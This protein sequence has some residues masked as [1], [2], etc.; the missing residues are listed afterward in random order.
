MTRIVSS[1]YRNGA[2][3]GKRVGMLEVVERLP[4]GKFRCVCDC[5]KERI[6]NV[7]HFN[8]GYAK[9]CGCTRFQ[10]YQPDAHGQCIIEGCESERCNSH[11]YCW[12]HYMRWRRHG[13]PLFTTKGRPQKWLLEHV[14]YEGDDCLS[15]PFG[16]RNNGY[17]TLV[18][19]GN[20]TSAHRQMCTLVHGDPPSPRHEAAHSCGNG[21][22]GCVNP[23]HLR[24]ATP[25][26]NQADKLLH[27]THNRGE[28]SGSA[29]LKERQVH[30]IRKMLAS[31]HKRAEIAR[32]F[33]VT[34]G[35]I[36]GIAY[37]KTWAWLQ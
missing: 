4:G 9:S 7:G 2:G 22:L 37:R 32:R 23:R 12:M 6:V 10:N 15:W 14:S 16:G 31:G 26:E 35:C 27:G 19:N 8:A 1:K 30:A 24:W 25:E 5:G 21:H 11:G 3:V 36:K 18:F 33:G 17:G 29:R 20:H 28:R 34:D 13:D